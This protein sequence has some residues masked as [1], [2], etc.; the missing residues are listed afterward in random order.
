MWFE[1]LQ[2]YGITALL[3]FF[4]LTGSIFPACSSPGTILTGLSSLGV[5]YAPDVKPDLIIQ[6]VT[7]S[8][9]NP[10]KGDTIT[11]SATVKNQGDTL[12]ISSTVRM[13]VD[14]YMKNEVFLESLDAG[15]A[16]VKEFTWTAQQG[17]QIFNVV[18]DEQNTGL[19]FVED[20]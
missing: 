4:L 1:K 16:S 8:P 2:K 3:T 18:V 20:T 11:I 6:S 12:S 14:G 15:S 19:P 10:S 5:L 7:W 17:S 13:Y 9:Q